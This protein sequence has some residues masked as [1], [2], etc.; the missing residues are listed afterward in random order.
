MVNLNRLLL[1]KRVVDQD[2]NPIGVSNDNPI[3][4]SRQYEIE[5]TDGVIEI[6]RAN[7]IVENILS[8]V[9]K[10]G[11]Q[12]QLLH[13]ICHHRTTSNACNPQDGYI[14]TKS[15][16]RIQRKTTQ[17]WELCVTWKGRGPS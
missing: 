14:C 7:N 4:D 6:L 8:Q 2:G 1:E 13:E 5:Y 15:G 16:G 12:Q 10:E 3:L 17:D 9:N 11:H